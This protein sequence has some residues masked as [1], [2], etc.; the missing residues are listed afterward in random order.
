MS[1]DERVQLRLD[2]SLPRRHLYPK[3]VEGSLV[4]FEKEA[5]GRASVTKTLAEHNR[6]ISLDA[7]PA[8]G[9]GLA[10]SNAIVADFF[11]QWLKPYLEM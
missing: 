9:A 3:E 1:A 5:E 2:K 7:N 11:K 6:R 10:P 4:D 8:A